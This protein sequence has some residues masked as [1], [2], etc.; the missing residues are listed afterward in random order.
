MFSAACPPTRKTSYQKDKAISE[1]NPMT[2]YD[3]Q[4]AEI[5][6]L[7]MI[8]IEQ[9]A[10]M[11]NHHLGQIDF[12]GGFRDA[13]TRKEAYTKAFDEETERLV[14]GDYTKKGINNETK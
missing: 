3:R 13:T 5:Y 12:L 7:R 6:W 2:I 1:R 11:R 10:A 9:R 4:A 8:I 14:F